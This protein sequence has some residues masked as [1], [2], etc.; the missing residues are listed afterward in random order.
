MIRLAPTR[1]LPPNYQ[2]AGKIDLSTDPRALLILN[3]VGLLLFI[4]SGAGLYRLALVFHPHLAGQGF[5]YAIHNLLDLLTALAW[6]LG[7]TGLMLLVHEGI[8]GLFFWAFT[9]SRPRFG[10]RG[11]YAFAA[12]P[13]WFIPRHLYLIVALSPV[14]AITLAGLVAMSVSSPGLILPLILLVTMNFSGSVGDMLVAGW[15][16]R[17]ADVDFAQDYGDGVQFY[18]PV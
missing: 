1:T 10:F 16:L 17:Q 18:R 5:S 3:G 14:I 13:D 11:Y 6:I 7:V 4:A 12:A 8:H 9:G 2:S 15:L